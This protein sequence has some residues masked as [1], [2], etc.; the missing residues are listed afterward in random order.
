MEHK[1]AKGIRYKTGF[2]TKAVAKWDTPAVN[3]ILT[4]EVYIGTLQQGKREEINYKLD[5]VVSK[6]RSDWIEI[7]DNHEA[8]ID[9][10]DFEIVQKLLKCDIKAKTVGEKAD[11]F[12]RLLFCKDCNAQMT[13]KV[14]KRGKT[15]TVYYICS[16]YNKGHNCSRHSIKQE[17][18][19]RTVLEMI[20]H[21]IQYLGEYETVSEKIK[22]ME[23]SYEQ[24][25]RIEKDR[26][27]PRK[28]RQN[29]NF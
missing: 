28:A 27:I 18:L 9:I 23:V 12:S 15:P 25:Q 29:L 4:N 2:S 26:N 19:Q 7:E 1:K 6:D 16:S 17:E 20:R 22:E 8:I 13:K 10:Y 14:D 5:K 21:Y 24:F 11:L 3:R